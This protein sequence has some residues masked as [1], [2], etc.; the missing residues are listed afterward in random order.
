MYLFIF[1]GSLHK[2]INYQTANA[3]YYVFSFFSFAS[4]AFSYSSLAIAI[5]THF[6]FSDTRHLANT[7]HRIRKCSIQ[8]TIA[9]T[10]LREWTCVSINHWLLSDLQRFI[11]LHCSQM[12]H[13][14]WCNT[15]CDPGYVLLD[16]PFILNISV[17]TNFIQ[18]INC[19][20]VTFE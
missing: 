15:V 3:C 17:D 9:T 8:N 7:A 11:S 6:G 5:R 16:P 2:I 1:R 18:A 4:C 14:K 20:N 10:Y 13:S 12:C 19:L